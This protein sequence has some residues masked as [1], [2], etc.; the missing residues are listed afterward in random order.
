MVHEPLEH[1][2]DVGFVVREASLDALFAGAA[3]AFTEVIT[4]LAGVRAQRAVEVAVEAPDLELLL[5]AFLE[6]LLHRFETERLLVARAETAVEEGPP[7]R[8]RGSLIGEA[9]E[10]PRHPLTVTVKAVTYHGLEVRREGEGWRAQVI[11]DV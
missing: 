2:A 7:A 5:V 10:A 8:L 9:F 1:T 4:P 6:E 3:A 11:L